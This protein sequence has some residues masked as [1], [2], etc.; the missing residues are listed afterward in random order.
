MDDVKYA[1]TPANE[2]AIE[3]AA[4]L[5]VAA[6]VDQRALL[7]ALVAVEDAQ[8]NV[9]AG[10]QRVAAKV[11]VEC[12]VVGVPGALGWIGRAIGNGQLMVGLG[13]LYSFECGAQVGPLVQSN[14]AEVGCAMHLQR[15]NSHR[16]TLY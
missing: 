4:Q 2:T 10:A 6:D 14:L 15:I 16:R 3:T 8:R 9:H 7:F 11:V 1:V 13:L 5:L 12:G